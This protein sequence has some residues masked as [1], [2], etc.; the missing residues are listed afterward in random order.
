MTV[1]ESVFF[2]SILVVFPLRVSGSLNQISARLAKAKTT[3]NL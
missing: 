1:D 2:Q 3:A